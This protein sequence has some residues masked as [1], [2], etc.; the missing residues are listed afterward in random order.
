MTPDVVKTGA[1]IGG[2]IAAG[3]VFNVVAMASKANGA[4]P[5][6]QVTYDND[7]RQFA[8]VAPAQKAGHRKR[9]GRVYASAGRAVVSRRLPIPVLVHGAD[10][11]P[12]A[13]CGWWMRQQLGMRDRA[14]NLARNWQHVGRAAQPAAGVIVVWRH[15]VG[16]IV[17]V[18]RPGVAIVESGNDGGIVR[19]R[20]RP[21]SNAIAFRE[22]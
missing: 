21:I 6:I 12:R 10:P 13:W 14:L 4:T 18:I 11:R 5:R 15:H 16:R 2:L 9:A 8:R 1:F 3:V 7:G 20:A 22:V 19:R 17:E